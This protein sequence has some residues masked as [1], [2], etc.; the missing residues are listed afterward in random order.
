MFYKKPL[1][2][3]SIVVSHTFAFTQVNLS[4]QLKNNFHFEAKKTRLSVSVRDLEAFKKKYVDRILIHTLQD[5]SNIVIISALHQKTFD[6]LKDD[7]NVLFIDHHEKV[8]EEATLDHVNSNF[9]RITK[10]H[11]AF[12]DIL[13]SNQKIS[14]KE[15]RFDT[16]DIDLKNRSFTTSVTPS[17]T[18]Q[19]A[20]TMA[21]LVGGGGNSS[22]RA[23]GV[24][25]QSQLTSSDFSNLSPDIVTIFNSNYIHLQNHSYGVGIEN[26]YGNEA[27]AYDLQVY[28]NPTLLHVFSSGNSGQS[29][30]TSGTYSN[31]TFANLTGNFKHAKNILVVN[32]VDTTLSI[33]SLNSRGPAFDGR[34]KPELTTFGQ[35]GT[36]EAAA[37]ASGISALVQEKYNV[38]NGQLPDASMVKAILIASSD[39]IGPKGID[40]LYGYGNINAYKALK[41][42]E[43]NQQTKVTM[44]SN[45]QINVPINIP[46]STSEIKIAVAWSDPPAAVNVNTVLINDIESWLDDGSTIT[47]PWTLNSYPNSDSLLAAPKRNADHFNNVEYITLANP[48]QGL[49]Q[50]VLK[51]GALTNSS[52]TVSVAYWMNQQKQF[53]WDFP[54]STQIIEGGKKNLLV[55][56]AEPNQKGDL[57]LQLNQGNWQLIKSGLD[58]NSYFYWSSPNQLT[59]AKLKMVIGTKEFVSG[60]FLISPLLKMSTAFSCADSIGLIWNA[61]KAP[62]SYELYTMGSQYLKKFSDTKDT[63]QVLPKSKDKF[64][65]VAPVLN[66]VTGLKSEAIDYTQQGAFCYLNLFAAARFSAL[67]VR[68]QLSLSSWYNVGHVIIFKTVN[69]GVPIPYKNISPSSSTQFIYFDADLISGA[70]VYQAEIFFKNGL[71]LFSDIIEIPIEEKGKVILYPNPVSAS[72]S[73]LNILSEGIGTFRVLDLFGRTVLEKDIR[74]FEDVLDVVNLP[75]GL[76]IYQFL[77]GDQVKDTGR[78]VKY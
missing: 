59:K 15:Q 12:P 17:T 16:S 7:A 30:P 66:G 14:I 11:F 20:T 53:S 40:Y 35:G 45:D 67:Q 56:E 3:L 71:T 25:P 55:W 48:P 13:G 73:D 75:A 74:L 46:A 31:L 50:L 39:D 41:L 24:V 51:S 78:F 47:L 19:H 69:N 60:E 28:Q 54:D 58:L 34:V 4:P 37:L 22:W 63:L 2:C 1:L 18:S 6:Q 68:V 76:Y 26:Y 64:F 38:T 32:A 23:T 62:V 36:S 33:N 27:V 42:V 5:Q 61:V 43:L 65:S 10:A 21:I 57:Y 29:K 77:S 8:R 44:A 70:M 49:Y 52:Q 9:N 72:K